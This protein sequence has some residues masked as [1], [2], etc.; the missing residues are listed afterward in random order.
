MTA[1][2][3]IVP[4]Q[5]P[6]AGTAFGT[7]DGS[8]DVIVTLPATMPDATYSVVCTPNSTTAQIVTIQ[9]TTNTTFTARFFNALTGAA[10]TGTGIVLNYTITD[11]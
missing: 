2:G 11:R 4:R 6:V 3:A 8:G 10:I 9:S 5:G 7:T 1:T